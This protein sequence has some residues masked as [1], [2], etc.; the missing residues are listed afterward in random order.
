MFYEVGYLF[1]I[2]TVKPVIGLF[3]SLKWAW[4][5]E[6]RPQPRRPKRSTT[7]RLTPSETWYSAVP[8]SRSGFTSAGVSNHPVVYQTSETSVGRKLEKSTY[9]AE[10]LRKGLWVVQ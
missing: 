3:R 9:L 7:Y 5:P 8:E 4:Q 6:R 1:T 10:Y 2:I